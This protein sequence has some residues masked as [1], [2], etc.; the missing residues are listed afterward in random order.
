VAAIDAVLAD[1]AA[2]GDELDELVSAIE[3]DRWQADTPSPGW[4]IAHQIGH[5]A[6]SDHFTVLAVTDPAEFESRRAGAASDFDATTDAAAA[7]GAALPPAELLADWRDSRVAVLRALA[8]VPAGQKVPWLVVPMAPA[9][10]ASTRLME[11]VGHGQDIRDAL[12]V[13]WKPTDRI[14]HLARLGYRTRDFAYVARGLQPPAT[15][16]RVELDSPGGGLWTFGPEDAQQRVTGAAADFCLLVTRR[17][18]RADLRLHADG[19]EA[20]RWLDFAQAYAGPPSAG[21]APG[22]FRPAAG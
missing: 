22:Q 17:R 12:G 20:D 18:H 1:L 15:E 5:L 3:P 6:S 14:V 16:F 10:L 11:L 8:T 7:E 2:E 19:E 4:T 9:S 13:S 21:R